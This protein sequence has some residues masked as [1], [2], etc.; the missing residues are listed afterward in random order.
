MA[1]TGPNRFHA[2][3][4]IGLLEDDH[5]LMVDRV[6]LPTAGKTTLSALATYVG[7]KLGDSASSAIM[8]LQNLGSGVGV[9]ASKSGQVAQLRSLRSTTSWLGLAASGNEISVS[10]N[11]PE[12]TPSAAGLMSASDK[13]K[14]DAG[15]GGGGGGVDSIVNIGPGAGVFAS[16]LADAAQFKSLRSTSSWLALTPAATEIQFQLNIPE[17]TPAAAGLFAASDKSKLDGIPPGG[18]GGGGGGITAIQN[19]GTGAGVF[20]QLSG[21][22]VQLKSLLSTTSQLAITAGANEVQFALNIPLASSTVAGLMIPADKVKLDGI[23]PATQATAGLLSA[24]DK[25]KLDTNVVP[26]TPANAGLMSATD[27][28]KLDSLTPGGGGTVTGAQNLGSGAG[29]FS[30]LSGSTIQLKSLLSTT[31]QLVITAATNDIQFSLNIPAATTS[32]AGLMSAGDKTKLDG[33]V[34]V[35]VTANGLMLATD[36]VKLDGIVP[37]TQTNNGLM[38]ATDKIKIDTQLVPATPTNLGTM[39]AADKTK[40]DGIIPVTTTANG[41]ML[42][43]DKV[44]LDGLPST[45]LGVVNVGNGTPVYEGVI[46]NNHRFRSIKG[47]SSAVTV[48]TDGAN[49]LT[50]SVASATTTAAGLMSGA[51][52]AKLDS[53]SGT[54][55]PGEPGEPYVD[56]TLVNNAASTINLSASAPAG[57]WFLLT[58]VGAVERSVL[59]VVDFVAPAVSFYNG[60]GGGIELVASYGVFNVA[61]G[62]L[63]GTT[64]AS[65]KFSISA[66]VDYKIHFENR[67]GTTQT[68]RY[69]NPGSGSGGGAV[70]LSQLV[71]VNVGQPLNND[72]LT[73]DQAAG[74]WLA[75]VGGG[76]GGPDPN[77]DSVTIGNVATGDK[78]LFQFDEATDRLLLT[79]SKAG[80]PAQQSLISFNADGDLLLNGVSLKPIADLNQIITEVEGI[81]D[82]TT[83]IKNEAAAQAELAR[84]WA[85]NPYGSPVAGG[86]Y[87][88]FHYSQESMLAAQNNRIIGTVVIDNTTPLTGGKYLLK[89][90]DLFKLLIFRLGTN[91]EVAVPAGLWFSFGEAWVMFRKEGA[92]ILSVVA[93]TTA[94][95]V[96][97]IVAHRSVV[98]RFGNPSPLTQATPFTEILNIPALSNAKV[99]IVMN[100]IHS[101]TGDRSVLLEVT[102]IPSATNYY[103][104]PYT[105]STEHMKQNGWESQPT[106]FA[107][108]DCSFKFTM[109]VGCVAAAATIIAINNAGTREDT[110]PVKSTGPQSASPTLV[111]EFRTNNTNPVGARL[112]LGSFFQRAH[113]ALPATL[114]GT[115]LRLSQGTTVGSPDGLDSDKFQNIGF[116]YG[117][118]VVPGNTVRNYITQ[119]AGAD[120]PTTA[121]ACAYPAQ[122]PAALTSIVRSADGKNTLELQDSVGVL[123]AVPDGQTY[124][125]NAG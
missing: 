25:I 57:A 73:W 116:A 125:F 29:V 81:R 121:L 18:G 42:A 74:K 46:A 96:P 38:L 117:Y 5:N 80:L 8:D 16:M 104:E 70:A 91:I 93:D 26:A 52:K 102:G 66:T 34:P 64:G 20:A 32:V 107:G 41:L 114:S 87:S 109:P 37:V 49:A 40:L 58:L 22:T 9:Y 111:P 12:A 67:L 103:N 69:F 94:V 98:R 84:K 97:R 119:F 17:A 106:L 79:V 124:F 108:G 44:K 10:L 113:T 89:S 54:P 45:V 13:A 21:T 101:T 83:A 112:C 99:N 95:S 14:L 92:G 90:G 59:V 3:D 50:I 2:L 1:T 123:H 43:T 120:G 19:L 118:E 48:G 7:I 11:I 35:T 85:A 115:M 4:L 53:L 71:D 78:A 24:A 65:D 60:P 75:K 47:G 100:S 36:K 31:S 15:V 51:D 63:T 39:S 72:V 62:V 56:F 61:T 6:G 33:I 55:E 28:S 68:V 86:Q 110:T 30:Q 88:S 122:N 77:F 23:G 76:G 27:K 82:E 105:G